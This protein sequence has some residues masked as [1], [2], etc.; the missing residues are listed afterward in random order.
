VDQRFHRHLALLVVSTTIRVKNGGCLIHSNL[1]LL[2]PLGRDFQWN[3]KDP[4]V[5]LYRQ[6]LR[7]QSTFL[8]V[9]SELVE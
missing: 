9:K 8:V 1:F 3:R 4:K 2:S 6:L 7:Q 5:F